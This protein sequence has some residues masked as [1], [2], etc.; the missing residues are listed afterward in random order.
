[1]PWHKDNRS[2]GKNV[3]AAPSAS[4]ASEHFEEIPLWIPKTGDVFNKCIVQRLYL[5]LINRGQ[6]STQTFLVQSF[7]TTLRVMDVRAENRGRPHQKVRFPAALVVGEKLFDPW[8]CGRKGQEC[9]REIRAKKFMF[10]LFF[11]PD[12]TVMEPLMTFLGNTHSTS[13][14]NGRFLTGPWDFFGSDKLQFEDHHGF[15][16]FHGFF[17]WR[18]LRTIRTCPEVLWIVHALGGGGPKLFSPTPP[19]LK[20][21][22]VGSVVFLKKGGVNFCRG[23]LPCQPKPPKFKGHRFAP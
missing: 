19:P 3:F 10:M 6:K 12:L 17:S 4:V 5:F 23:G 22:G 11:F 8:A 20:I 21:L 1:M 15:D 13:G 7:S 14:L 18:I 2:R 9:P 16:S